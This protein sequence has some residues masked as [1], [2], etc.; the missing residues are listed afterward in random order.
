MDGSEAN[1]AS[2]ETEVHRARATVLDQAEHSYLQEQNA[3]KVVE[4]HNNAQEFL[5]KNCYGNDVTVD[6]PHWVRYHQSGMAAHMSYPQ[7]LYEKY[8]IP[9]YGTNELDQAR[10]EIAQAKA[11]LARAMEAHKTVATRLNQLT[12]KPI[13]DLRQS[14]PGAFQGYSHLGGLSSLHSYSI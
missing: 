11:D 5:E 7:Y 10:Q 12:G 1:I 14:H 13:E 6:N 4:S 8:N 3:N 9:Y 2:L